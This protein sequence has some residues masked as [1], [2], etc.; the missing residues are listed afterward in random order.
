M[1][2]IFCSG[3]EHLVLIF[4]VQRVIVFWVIYGEILGTALLIIIAH[5]EFFPALPDANRALEVAIC[6]IP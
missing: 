2:A 1:V 5:V 6:N 3:F 4:L